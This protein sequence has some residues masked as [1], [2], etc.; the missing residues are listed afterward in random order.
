LTFNFESSLRVHDT[1]VGTHIGPES[2]DQSGV[3]MHFQ[4]NMNNLTVQP[5][6]RGAMR[7]LSFPLQP[8]T[9]PSYASGLSRRAERNACLGRWVASNTSIIPAAAGDCV[10]C[11]PEPLGTTAAFWL[12]LSTFLTI[13]SRRRF[14]YGCELSTSTILHS[15]GAAVPSQPTY[16]I[17]LR[18]L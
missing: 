11:G 13:T 8:A 2:A 18:G 4:P 16:T 3:V 10:S 14:I 9:T 6:H 17:R 15:N 1:Q 7:L 5:A 12:N